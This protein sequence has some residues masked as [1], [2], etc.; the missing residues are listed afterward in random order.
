[1]REIIAKSEEE[2]MQFYILLGIFYAF[3]ARYT[4][5]QFCEIVNN[6]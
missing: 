6:S 3:H 5:R 2:K 4:Y 1:M